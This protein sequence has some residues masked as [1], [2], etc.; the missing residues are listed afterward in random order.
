VEVSQVREVL[1]VGAGFSGAVIARQ[2]ADHGIS[3]RICEARGHIGGNCYSYRHSTNVEHH[4]YGPHI[5]HTDRSDVWN[6]VQRF[7]TFE[8]YEHQVMATSNS[9]VYGLPI[10]LHTLNQFFGAQWNPTEARDFLLSL[11]RP[12]KGDSFEDVGISLVGEDLFNEFFRG[13][14][15]K[16]WGRAASELPGDVFKRLPIR[17]SY[18]RS[19][20]NHPYQG[21]PIGGYSSLFESLLD[22]KLI[23]VELNC[24]IQASDVTNHEIVVF[25]GPIDQFF[26]YSEGR[27]S[28]RTVRF[29]LATCEGPGQGCAQMNYTSKSVPHTRVTDFGYLTPGWD[30]KETLL[31]KEFSYETGESDEPYYPVRDA[32]SL[33]MFDCYRRRAEKIS[34]VH[35]VGRLARYEYLDMDR[36][37]AAALDEASKLLATLASG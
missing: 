5:F 15:E 24:P 33:E 28:Y 22:S 3:A 18:G 29:E 2:L 25:T 4:L 35:F 9:G 1:I 27:L 14:T 26:G 37:I 11:Q 16:Q 31:A 19:Y 20:F 8:P 6:F 10:N 12:S 30:G 23:S 32:S 21:L 36:T 34:N 17:F 7:S 13:Y